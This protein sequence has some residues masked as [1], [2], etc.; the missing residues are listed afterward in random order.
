MPVVNDIPE[1]YHEGFKDLSAL[2][3]QEFEKVKECL[4]KIELVGSIEGL[5]IQLYQKLD[6][7]ETPLD[8]IFSSIS[9][10]I[11]FI[12][13][14]ETIAEIANDIANLSIEYELVS[15]DNLTEYKNRLKYL[16][17][18]K[19]IYI[20]SKAEDLLNDYSNSYILSRVVSD[21]RPVFSIDVNEDLRAGMILHNLSIHYQSNDE[22]Y[23]KTI[24]LTLSPEDVLDLKASL[25]R[26]DIKEK[27][28]QSVLEK[29]NMIYLNK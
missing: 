13:N 26:A 25:D 16:L 4:D 8:D 6:Q 18:N 22:P 19:H 3:Q 2:N 29:S 27:K 15:E 7:F 23:H 5:L 9:S 1:R 20:A 14:K 11:T 12:Q 21:I 28:L 17:G 10:I 24:T